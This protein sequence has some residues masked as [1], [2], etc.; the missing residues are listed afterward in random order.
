MKRREKFILL[1]LAALD[2]LVIGILGFLVWQTPPPASINQPSY[3][4]CAEFLM[5][6][7]PSHLSPT[8]SWETDRLNVRMTAYYDVPTPP[9]GSAQLLWEAL[10][11]LSQVTNVGCPLPSEVVIIVTAQG[12]EETIGHIARL[13]GTD[14]SDWINGEIGEDVLVKRAAYRVSSPE[15]RESPPAP[16]RYPQ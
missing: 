4:P 16:A 10:D 7:L 12:T 11:A 6:Q 15:P 2:V 8:T 5:R 1:A 13:T 3:T 14:L 9:T